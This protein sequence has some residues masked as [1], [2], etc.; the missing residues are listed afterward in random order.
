[1]CKYQEYNLFALLCWN[2]IFSFSRS[3]LISGTVYSLLLWIHLYLMAILLF[4][5]LSIEA[6]I[7]YL[8]QGIA[9][10]NLYLYT[11]SNCLYLHLILQIFL[12]AFIFFFYLPIYKI[13][14]LALLLFFFFHSWLSFSLFLLFSFF[15]HFPYII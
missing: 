7:F 2:S 15:L 9:Y 5:I 11:I 14:Y 8:V 10:Q 6:L 4:L 1:M 12:I 13:F 3:I